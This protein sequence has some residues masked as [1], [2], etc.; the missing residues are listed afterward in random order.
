MFYPRF[1][2]IGSNPSLDIY[3]GKKEMAES[4]GFEPSVQA[5]GPYNGLANRRLR[6]LGQLSARKTKNYFL[7]EGDLPRC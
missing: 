4:E 2:R 7:A 1:A 3:G 6:P 5:L